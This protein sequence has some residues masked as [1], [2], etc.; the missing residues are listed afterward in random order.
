MSYAE[1]WFR[2]RKC[3]AVGKM[4]LVRVAEGVRFLINPHEHGAEGAPQR[5]VTVLFEME[6]AS[7]PFLGAVFGRI[8]G[9]S[10]SEALGLR[11]HEGDRHILLPLGP[12]GMLFKV[13][14]P[15]G[16]EDS[17]AIIRM[18]EACGEELFEAFPRLAL[19]KIVSGFSWRGVFLPFRVLT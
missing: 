1:I 8:R 7:H 11:A 18:L 19:L 12:S 5:S 3:G 15:L 6:R 14:G 4:Y 10:L 2:C 13:G 17:D 9:R 16:G